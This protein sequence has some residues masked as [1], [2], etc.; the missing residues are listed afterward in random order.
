MGQ[1]NNG[2]AKAGKNLELEVVPNSIVADAS[3]AQ[4]FVGK[5]NICRINGTAGGFA[6]FQDEG[7]TTVPSSSTEETIQTELGFFKIVATKDYIRTSA[8]M[9]IEITKD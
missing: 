8:L 4:F 5:G 7:D 9:R 6:M 3:A 2:R 1:Y